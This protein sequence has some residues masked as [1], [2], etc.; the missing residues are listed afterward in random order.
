M[1]SMVG[2]M[3]RCLGTMDKN[4]NPCRATVTPPLRFEERP[5]AEE[6]AAPRQSIPVND[7]PPEHERRHDMSEPTLPEIIASG[8]KFPE[9]P[10]AMPDGTVLFVEIGAGQLSRWLP[11]GRIVVAAKTGGGPNG[12]AIGP[13]GACYVCN[14]GG[15]VW[16]TDPDGGTY[17]HGRAAD[18]AGG[19]I[20]RVDLETGKVERLYDRTDKGPLSGPNDIVFDAHGGFWFTDLGNMA[21]GAIERGRVCYARADGSFIREVVFPMLT[22]NGI[23]LSPDGSQLYVAETVTARVWAFD[24][25]APG[26]LDLRGWPALTPGRLLHAPGHY[27]MYDSL[28]VEADGNVCVATIG[29]GG[30]TV[31]SPAGELV[32]F[33]PMPDRSTTNICFGGADMR[34]AYITLSRSGRLAKTS[35]KRPGLVLNA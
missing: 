18:Y 21:A 33:V 23:G 35:W 29:Q 28:G 32:E 13:D 10:I 3:L 24:V 15:F 9:G 25:K 1:V 26:E 11:G 31:I 22:P 20:E 4:R 16:H 27:C 7:E 5:R 19:R 34:S 12:A 30:I 17:P 2:Q 6:T 14:N 8:L